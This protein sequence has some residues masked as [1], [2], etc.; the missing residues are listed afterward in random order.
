MCISVLKVTRNP[1][2]HFSNTIEHVCFYEGRKSS[3][4]RFIFPFTR[5]ILK[6]FADDEMNFVL[7]ITQRKKKE[8]LFQ[9]PLPQLYCINI[10]KSELRNKQTKSLVI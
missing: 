1:F 3:I 7:F 8:K 10:L 2:T 5:Y 9:L 6:F 4:Y